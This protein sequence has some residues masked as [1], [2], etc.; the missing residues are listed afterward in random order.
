MA[1]PIKAIRQ[2]QVSGQFYPQDPAELS[3]VLNQFLSQPAEKLKVRALVVPHAGYVFSGQVAGSAFAYL[4]NQKYKKIILIGPSHYYSFAGLAVDNHHAYQTPLGKVLVSDRVNDLLKEKNFKQK[5]EAFE[6]EHDLE[7]ELPFLQK[8]LSGFEIIPLLMGSENSLSD[9]REMAA[10]MKK[11]YDPQTLIVVSADFTHYGPNFGFKPFTKDIPQNLTKLDDPVID[12]LT[13]GQTEKLYDYLHQVA[14]TN[15]GQNVLPWLAEIAK[16]Q[17]LSA[18]VA[19][20]DTSGNITGD[21]ENSV[22]YASLV[23]YPAPLL[24]NKN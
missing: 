13:A 23:F 17:K 1:I 18:K 16:D 8:V 7:V 12:F 9:I 3:L 10:I 21:Y 19:A 24:S 11:Y 20:R 4:K 2:P 22:S 6:P 14:V 5:P 15:D